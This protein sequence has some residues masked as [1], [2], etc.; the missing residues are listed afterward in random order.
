M[1]HRVEISRKFRENRPT[2]FGKLR[3]KMDVHGNFVDRKFFPKIFLEKKFFRKFVSKK[4]FDSLPFSRLNTVIFRSENFRNFHFFQN[5]WKIWRKFRRKIS[6][7]K[8]VQLL[9]K[10]NE[11]K[12][13]NECAKLWN[14]GHFSSI[15]GHFSKISKFVKIFDFL[16][17]KWPSGNTY[18]T[19]KNTKIS[20]KKIVKNF[21]HI[22]EGGAPGSKAT[23]LIKFYEKKCFK[24]IPRYRN[25]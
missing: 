1:S 18:Q 11:Y 23:F 5:F 9:C 21:S 22:P 13:E 24:P 6:W 20:T 17:K 16:R 7:Q 15:F 12:R 25:F 10:I 2:N 4:F 3:T 19:L 14:L 8:S